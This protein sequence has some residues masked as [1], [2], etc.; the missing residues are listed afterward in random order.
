MY[1]GIS[2]RFVNVTDA[3]LSLVSRGGHC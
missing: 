1:Y 3:C 2:H